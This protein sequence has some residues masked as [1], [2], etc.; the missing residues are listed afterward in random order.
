M[1]QKIASFP[2]I[3]T[4]PDHPDSDRFEFIADALPSCVIFDNA[5]HARSG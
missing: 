1:R 2:E 4:T 3:D 5:S